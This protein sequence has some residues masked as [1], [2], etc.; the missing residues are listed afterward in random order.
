MK[1]LGFS[2]IFV[3]QFSGIYGI[4]NLINVL[5]NVLMAT[6]SKDI[7]IMEL[8]DSIS[9]QRQMNK[10]LQNALDASTSQVKELTIQ[11]SLLNEQMEYLKKK[12]FG[13]SSE[14]HVP[15]DNQISMFNEAEIEAN[16]EI[17]EELLETEVTSHKRKA[18]TTLEEKIKGI[19]IEQVI[20]EL[21]SEEQFCDLCGHELERMGQEVIR[22]E[23]EYI[24]AKVKIIEYVSI[25]YVCPECK[26]TEE[27]FFAKGVSQQPLMKHSLASPSS[28]AWV[29]YQK[30]ANGLPLYR[31]EKDW[32]QYGI[33]LSRAT[34]AN[35]VIF[36]ALNY[37]KP[38]Y[39]YCH[40]QLIQ[41][42]F[43]MADETR[44]QVLKEDN[45]AAETDSFMWLYRSGEDGLPP[46]ILFEYSMTRAGTTAI[47][48][49]DGFKGYLSCDGYSGYNKV[50]DI[51]RCGCWAHV[52]RYYVDAIAKGYEN[53]LSHPAV[54]GAEFCS[55]LFHYEEEFKKK[56]YTP[57]K[58]KELRL[59]KA[60]PILEAFWSWIETQ[61]P[62]KNSRM[63]KA[64][65]YSIHQRPY[66]ETFLEDGRCSLSNNLAE[67]S[68]R[69][70]TVGRKGWLFCDSPKGATSSA[71]VYSV[72][73]MAKANGLNIYEYLNFL[74]KQRL[75]ETTDDL[76]LDL[77]A[78]WG[79]KAKSLC[80][81]K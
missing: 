12:L 71:I 42:E 58:R 54:Q 44:V 78:P 69:P 8:K 5:E 48:F 75:S 38:L 18:K 4:I 73:E 76:E 27:P 56:G 63:D 65:Q 68:I 29:M 53:N 47:K 79:Q 31:Q 60:K 64:I 43:L 66:L 36:T 40:R 14:R 3:C 59:K 80:S 57:E 32:K 30:Y 55:K 74:L 33:N 7:L 25:H 28:V 16:P 13:T 70:F 51:K 52:R 23:L 19:P 67:N 20:C 17:V 81:L 9:E 61:T 62:V 46:I 11:V 34:M 6:S 39:D 22:R 72:V 2:C 10:T 26:E 21:P 35:W 41:R 50:P 77:I 45:R 24:P 1:I 37:F 15:L 49:L